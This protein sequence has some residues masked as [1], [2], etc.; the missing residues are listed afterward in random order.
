[1]GIVWSG[2]EFAATRLLRGWQ[3]PEAGGIYA[4]SH[5]VQQ[6]DGT[7]A[8]CVLYFGRS[9]DLSARGI[10]PSHEKYECWIRHADGPLY[11]SIHREDD[12]RRRLYKERRLVKACKP[13]CNEAYA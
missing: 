1:M 4:I 2:Y 9:N 5:I 7:M 10:G 3:A 12:H 11:V 6:G 13:V 8:P